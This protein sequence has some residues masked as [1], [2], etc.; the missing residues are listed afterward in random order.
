MQLLEANKKEAEQAPPVKEEGPNTRHASL[1][2]CNA[3]KKEIYGMLVQVRGKKAGQE[4]WLDLHPE[5]HVCIRCKKQFE[6]DQ[7]YVR[8]TAYHTV[9]EPCYASD[10]AKTKPKQMQ[11]EIQEG[12]DESLG[13]CLKCNKDIFLQATTVKGKLFHPECH[14]CKKCGKILKGG[15]PFF[16]EPNNEALCEHCG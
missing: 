13:K 7:T 14:K 10:L 12:V 15:D 6:E 5:C 3:C 1:G 4:A 9:C 16:P 11:H 8:D 2:N